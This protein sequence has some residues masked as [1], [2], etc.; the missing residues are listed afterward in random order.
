MIK[1]G[2][3]VYT[4][5]ENILESIVKKGPYDLIV[6]IPSY[7]NSETIKYVVEMADQGLQQYFPNMRACIINSDGGSVDGTRKKFLSSDTVSDLYSF[8]YKGIPGK[9]TAMRSIFEIAHVVEA[10]AVVFLDSDLRSVEPFWIERL[11]TPILEG[12]TSYVTPYYIRHKYDGTITNS[13]C[14]PLTSILYGQKIR[15]PIGGDFGVG[16]ELINIYVRKPVE[17]WDSDIS[18]FGIDIWMTT[19]AINESKLPVYQASLGAKIHDVKDPGKH[20]EN[21]F[22]EVVG[23]LFNLMEVYKEN[24]MNVDKI[25]E[26]PVYGDILE[27]EPEPIL[28]DAKNLLD[29]CKSGIISMKDDIS[30]IFSEELTEKLFDIAYGNGR[31]NEEVWISVIFEL[32]KKYKKYKEELIK[33]LVPI[34][35][36]KTGDF[37]LKTWDMDTKEAEKKINELLDKFFE[38]KGELVK[39]WMK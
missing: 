19:T 39:I 26:S 14:Y 8:V 5:P 37:V 27:V 20:L 1:E 15:Q 23:T 32:S 11:L 16:K 21:M 7:N 36:G 35:F 29:R 34:Y 13:I 3:K 12:K 30:K 38:R 10:K 22:K 4:V 2:F 33:V 9:G 31:I 24:W 25:A 17:I 28:V 18:K 6:G